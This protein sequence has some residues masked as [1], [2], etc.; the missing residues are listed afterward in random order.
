MSTTRSARRGVT[1]RGAAREFFRHPTPWMILAYL[2]GVVIA[3][4]AVGGGGLV[5]LWAPLVFVAL[6]P[7]LEWVIHVFV[8]HWR[9]RT[10]G[11]LTIDT[12]LARDHR[13]HHAAPRDVDLVFIPTRALPWVI[14]GLGVAVP[15]AIGALVGAP[16]HAT[17]NFMLVEGLV[18][19][20]YEWTH[21]LIH[22][23]YKPRGRFYK[24]VWRNHRHH[25]FKNEHYWFTVTTTGT[26]DRILRTSPDP[27]TVDA[28]PTAKKLHGLDV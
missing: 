20:G 21:Y 1:L 23:D 2:A 4:A 7:L 14:A 16:V 22:T 17:L 5:D 15:L 11:R 13:R 3:R 6:F 27:A 19:L 24:A 8:L 10:V 9:P 25:H 12:L 18:L 28:S 26:A